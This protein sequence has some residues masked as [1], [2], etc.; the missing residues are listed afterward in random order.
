MITDMDMVLRS[1]K[2]MCEAMGGPDTSFHFPSLRDANMRLI[3][4]VQPDE[5]FAELKLHVLRAASIGIVLCEALRN[6][7]LYLGRLEYDDS[8]TEEQS[9]T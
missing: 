5:Y 2:S 7:E 1:V 6:G 9:K 8:V 4:G 3:Q